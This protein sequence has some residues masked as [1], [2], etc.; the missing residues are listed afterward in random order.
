MRRMTKVLDDFREERVNWGAVRKEL[1]ENV[2]RFE[3]S[4]TRAELLQREM[5]KKGATVN[6]A[7]S[8]HPPAVP[9]LV[10]ELVKDFN[11]TCTKGFHL[12]LRESS[13]KMGV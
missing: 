12:V 8:K 13:N 11:M 4:G 3:G 7:S 10:Q 5:D 2:G 6:Q 1:T 9:A